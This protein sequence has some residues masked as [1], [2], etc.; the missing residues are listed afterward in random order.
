MLVAGRSRLET[1]GLILQVIM[2]EEMGF[3]LAVEKLAVGPLASKTFV[4]E[5]LPAV[6]LVAGILVWLGTE[7]VEEY[8]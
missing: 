6:G 3:E 8:C 4:A 7:P 1:A 5:G 2:P